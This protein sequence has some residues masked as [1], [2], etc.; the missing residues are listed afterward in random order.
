MPMS[1]FD[2]VKTQQALL[3]LD[4]SVYA[5][6]SGALLDYVSFYGIHFEKEGSCRQQCG[7]FEAYGYR[8]SAHLFLPESPKGTVWI[9]HGYFDHV[10]LYG[11][12]IR[13]CLQRG[14]AVFAYD[15]PGH[16]L[17]SGD[18]SAIPDF[19]HYQQVLHEALSQFGEQLPKPFK[20]LGQSTGGGILM[21]YLLSSGRPSAF[22]GVLL[23][24]PLVHPSNWWKVVL[25]HH[26]LRHFVD[27][28]P[29]TFRSNTSD[30]AFLDFVRNKDPLQDRFVSSEWV[31]AMCRWAK[32]MEQLPVSD[33]SPL[34]V[35]GHG[36]ETVDW[37]FNLAFIR[38]HF[39]QPVISEL[40]LASHHLANERDDLRQPVHEMLARLLAS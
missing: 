9:M 39:T 31:G 28:V 5:P 13:D 29:R 17:S 12:L 37:R 7:W 4:P 10:G 36:D 24:A 14:Y 23:L 16:G 40:E 38:K 26:V 27:R 33:F 22:D 18:R 8:L 11:R 21:D 1:L 25:S 20:A 2:P 32:H 6:V 34:V 15:L 35:Q 30:E 3:R 19:D